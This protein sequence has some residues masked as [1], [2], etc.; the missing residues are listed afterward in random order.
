MF[1][2]TRR[3]APERIVRVLPEMAISLYWFPW[4]L[5]HLSFTSEPK[6]CS[7]LYAENY[8]PNRY[9]VNDQYNQAVC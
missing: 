7:C 2:T 6:C 3:R 1:Q 4:F 8:K 5:R 9:S